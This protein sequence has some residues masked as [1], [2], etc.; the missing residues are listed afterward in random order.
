M[1]DRNGHDFHRHEGYDES[2]E[3]FLTDELDH[4][5]LMH[6]E[7]HFGGSFDE[8]LNY[9][10]EERLG[11]HPDFELDRIEYLAA[12]EKETGSNLASMLLSGAEAERIAVARKRYQDFKI[13]YEKPRLATHHARLIA[14]LV[15]TEN[16]EP[17]DE[18]EAIVQEGSDIVSDLI[19]I[20]KS[21]EAYDPLFPGYGYAP[22]F[23]IQALGNIKD[24][25]AIVAIFETLSK[26]SHFG[27]EAALSALR[28]IGD[29]AKEFLLKRAASRP[30]TKDNQVAVY[31]LTAFECDE[32]ISGA[33][34]N[35]LKDPQVQQNTLLCSY[36]L[37][38][39]EELKEREGFIALAKHTTLPHDL[40]IEM[41]RIIRRWG[42]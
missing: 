9:Y 6:R 36:L 15:L 2:E 4:E 41:E 33:C 28:E 34:F 3:N 29:P 37:I 1:S 40:K 26:E 24:P 13:I 42:K 20:I 30:L 19:R 12:V 18:I 5:I 14:D 17:A 35:Q 16:E 27:D 38:L 11:A 7:V 10:E 8:M 32:E 23:A 39:C 31:A 22:F 25:T 21:D